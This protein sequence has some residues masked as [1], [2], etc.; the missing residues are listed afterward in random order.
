MDTGWL[1]W[2][3]SVSPDQLEGPQGEAYERLIA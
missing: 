1:A 2:S 3:C